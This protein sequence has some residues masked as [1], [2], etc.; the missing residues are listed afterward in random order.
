MYL[1]GRGRRSIIVDG[2]EVLVFLVGG[3]VETATTEP[4][5]ALPDRACRLGEP[6]TLVPI[7][8]TDWDRP[9]ECEFCVLFFHLT[10]SLVGLKNL[11]SAV[12]LLFWG[13]FEGYPF[14]D[15][16]G[17]RTHS[18]WGCHVVSCSSHRFWV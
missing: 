14:G 1:L 11:S 7:G 5:R 12:W 6:S 9:P 8:P 13:S 17:V 10:L 16:H 4:G 2:V 18:S 15:F 3:F